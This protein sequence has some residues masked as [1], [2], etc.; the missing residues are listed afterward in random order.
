T[1][2]AIY[3]Q[4]LGANGDKQ[5]TVVASYRKSKSDVFSEGDMTEASVATTHFVTSSRDMSIDAHLASDESGALQWLVGATWLEFDQ[6]QDI[7]VPTVIPLGFVAPGEPLNV[8]FP[9]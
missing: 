1:L 6:K 4:P 2:Q 5:L 8:P 7:D 3:D 9:L